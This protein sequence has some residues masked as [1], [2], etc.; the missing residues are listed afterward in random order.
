MGT[1][2]EAESARAELLG[3]GVGLVAEFMRLA[4]VAWY[5]DSL[6]WAWS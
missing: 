3:A 4:S 5:Q 2:L 1:V 6:G